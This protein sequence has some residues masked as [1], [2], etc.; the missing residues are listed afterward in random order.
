MTL[1]MERITVLVRYHIFEYEEMKWNGTRSVERNYLR[2]VKHQFDGVASR[3][4]LALQI[5]NRKASSLRQSH[6]LRGL[7]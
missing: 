6:V 4:G 5:I 1:L 3:R 7:D 2:R